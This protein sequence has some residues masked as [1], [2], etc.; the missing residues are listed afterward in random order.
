MHD[1]GSGSVEG[2]RI[3]WAEADLTPDQPVLVSGQFHARVS[4]AV[5]DPVTATALAIESRRP[6]GP[7]AQAV[8]VG[9]DFV[10]IPDALRDDVRSRLR[11]V[12]PDLDPMA[13]F[14]NATHTHTGPEPRVHDDVLQAG[15]GTVAGWT[16]LDL[17]VM[18]PAQYAAMAAERIAT[19]VIRAWQSRE[20]GRIGFGLGQA[21]IGYNRR[22]CY[23]GGEARMYGDPNDPDFTHIEGATD[24]NVNVLYTQDRA[25]RL[26][27]VVVNVACPAQVGEMDFQISADY[28]HE[29]R[30]EL[31]GRLG[32]DLHVLPQCSAAGDQVTAKSKILIGWPAQE[33]MWRLMGRTQRQDI[34]ARI[35]DAVTAALP[36][37]EKEMADD[38]LFVHRLVTV[39]LPRRPVTQDEANEATAA[40][41]NCRRQYESLLA[42]LD[43]HPKKRNEPRW[44][45]PITKAYR[46]MR[47]NQRV[48]ERFNTERDQPRVPIE[49]HVLRLGDVAI[50]TNPF[51][52]YLDYG[53]RI[54][55][56]S[57]AI[58]TF[59]VQLTGSGTYVP[60]ERAVAGKGYGAVPASSPVGPEGGAE[61]ADR[62]VAMIRELWGLS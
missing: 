62:T 27:G 12:L 51:E 59:L 34:A 40:A 37:A 24:P 21:V 30:R 16:G 45:V 18:P 41:E 20:P 44:Y 48:V 4:E 10:S 29:T 14:L 42:D 9:C 32:A 52:Y 3:G 15:G 57:P 26:T 36:Y 7:P 5:A 13:V 23:R 58:Q 35:A 56:R 53:L 8:L 1:G 39:E 28:W 17:P 61:L 31:R 55:A 54:K 2:L 11:S 19:A 33:R 43:A 38:P 22:M 50:A 49:A 6:D 47:W 60:T 25:G 46:Q